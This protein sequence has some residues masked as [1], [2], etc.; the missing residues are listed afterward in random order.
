MAVSSLTSPPLP[1]PPL[2][3]PPSWLQGLLLHRVPCLHPRSRDD[4]CCHAH[5]QGCTASTALP[6]AILSWSAPPCGFGPRRTVRPP[7]VW[8]GPFNYVYIDMFGSCPGIV[9][10]PRRRK[11]QLSPRRRSLRPRR[12][13]LTNLAT[14]FAIVHCKSF[15]T[16]NYQSRKAKYYFDHAHSIHVKGDADGST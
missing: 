9:T 6:G 2:Q 7:K 13:R 8:G 3:P 5:L 4:H 11:S 15:F 16:A 12:Q 10:T 14:H 1:S